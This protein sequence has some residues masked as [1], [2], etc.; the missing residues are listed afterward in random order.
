MQRYPAPETMLQHL[1]PTDAAIE[2]LALAETDAKQF[3]RFL[4][5]RFGLP[6]NLALILLAG[7]LG[8]FH[9]LLSAVWSRIFPPSRKGANG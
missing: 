4:P 3:D 2:R 5:L 9:A 1:K 7:G 6:G 8:V